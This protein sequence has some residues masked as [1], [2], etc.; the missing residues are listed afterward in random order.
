MR[1]E[2]NEPT[3]SK[4]HDVF[5]DFFLKIRTPLSP[6]LMSAEGVYTKTV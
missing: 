1:A 5:Q 3:S 2:P 4:P 6:E